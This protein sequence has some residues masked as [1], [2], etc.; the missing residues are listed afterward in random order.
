MNPFEGK[1]IRSRLDRATGTRWFSVVD[2]CAAVLNCD[3]QKARSYW[4]WL[5]AKH[6]NA[7]NEASSISYQLKFEAADGKMRRTDVMD[8][9]SILGLLTSWPKGRGESAKNWFA[10]LANEG[11]KA[12][13]L[14]TDAIAD[15]KCRAGNL[16]YTVTRTVIYDSSSK[17]V[18]PTP[19]RLHWDSEKGFPL[20]YIGVAVKT[21]QNS[22]ASIMPASTSLPG[23]GFA[24]IKKHMARCA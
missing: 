17:L 3:Y 5:K 9:S 22:D 16:L 20:G 15:I 12:A 24:N 7:K 10:K 11:K 14:V 6:K 13:E 1:K 8:A 2:V 23:H 21:R 18:A 4:K 19:A